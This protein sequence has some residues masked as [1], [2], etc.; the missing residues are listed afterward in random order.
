MARKARNKFLRL[1]DRLSETREERLMVNWHR[2]LDLM[3]NINSARKGWIV[4]N[5]RMYF[6]Y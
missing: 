1:K 6:R 5:Y 4:G 2:P 3:L